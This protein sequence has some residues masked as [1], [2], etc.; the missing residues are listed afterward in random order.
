MSEAGVCMRNDERGMSSGRSDYELMKTKK[1]DCAT[2]P[3]FEQ[4]IKTDEYIFYKI[5]RKINLQDYLP[6]FDIDS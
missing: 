3:R 6:G 5:N 1:V 4:I 2:D